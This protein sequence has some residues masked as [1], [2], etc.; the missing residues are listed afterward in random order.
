MRRHT[1]VALAIFGST[2]IGACGGDDDVVPGSDDGDD[3]VEI[4]TADLSF[5]S[6]MIEAQPATSLEIT[7]VNEDSATHSVTF[8][9]LSFD[10][11]AAGGA[12]GSGTL[13]VPEGDATYTFLCKYHPDL[14]RG[15]LVVGTGGEPDDTDPVPPGDDNGYDY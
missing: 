4:I 10:L 13:E 6:T 9:E 7:L 8:E 1:L 11:E 3:S 14:M 15:A 12:Q 5:S 2:L